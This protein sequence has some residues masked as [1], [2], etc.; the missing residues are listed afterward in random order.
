MPTHRL[1]V[2]TAWLCLGMVALAGFVPAHGFVLCLE[3]DGSLGLEAGSAE[4]RC[5]GCEVAG[6]PGHAVTAGEGC[7]CTDIPL[8]KLGEARQLEPRV[9]E[10]R[11]DVLLEPSPVPAAELALPAAGAPVIAEASFAPPPSLLRFVRSVVLQV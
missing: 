11:L 3:P 1:H 5:G 6:L 7:S 10:V 4:G 9:L 2:L 8:A